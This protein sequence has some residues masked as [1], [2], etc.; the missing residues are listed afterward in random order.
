M[1]HTFTTTLQNPTGYGYILVVP[2]AIV[3]DF[4]DQHGKRVVVTFNQGHRWHA[5]LMAHGAFGHYIMVGK[6]QLKKAGLDGDE[7][8][9][10]ELVADTSKYGA[11]VPEELEAVL[12]TDPEGQRAFEGMTDGGKRSVIFMVARYK[13]TDSRIEKALDVLEKLK[14]GITDRKIL[15]KKGF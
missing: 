6:Q 3:Q 10:V 1:R 13:T 14:L 7:E 2:P 8:I 4:L 9:E 5:A 15:G 12:E 11:E